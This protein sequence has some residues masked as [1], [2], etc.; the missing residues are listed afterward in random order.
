[1]RR[2]GYN[3]GCLSDSQC[4]R[5][6]DRLLV[7]H[8]FFHSSSAVPLSFLSQCFGESPDGQDLE[9]YMGAEK[10]REFKELFTGWIRTIYRT[11]PLIH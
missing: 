11:P 2:K 8:R 9:A 4:E 10:T 1:M 3:V 6:T 7:S 5:K